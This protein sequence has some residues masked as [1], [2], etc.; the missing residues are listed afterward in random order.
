MSHIKYIDP[1]VTMNRECIEQQIKKERQEEAERRREEDEQQY[2][3]DHRYDKEREHIRKVSDELNND[4][5][6]IDNIPTKVTFRNIDPCDV[7]TYLTDKQL[8]SITSTILDDR[9]NGYIVDVES[10]EYKTV[11]SIIPMKYLESLEYI[12]TVNRNVSTTFSIETCYK[13]RVDTPEKPEEVFTECC[14]CNDVEIDEY[15]KRRKYIQIII[16]KTCTC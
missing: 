14:P 3:E 2:A 4:T 15:E 5:L 6:N 11:Y 9:A 13:L 7:H 1:A 16:T 12:V 10:N 8:L